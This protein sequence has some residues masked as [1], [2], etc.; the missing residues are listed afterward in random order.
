MNRPSFVRIARSHWLLALL[1]WPLLAAGH[2]SPYSYLVLQLNAAAT[3]G[4]L[5]MHV[6]D[7]AH[8]TGVADPVTL[9]DADTARRY[10]A[11][12][13][14]LAATRMGI[15]FDGQTAEYAWQP[16]VVLPE[17]QSLQL[18]FTLA[19][20]L[21][22]AVLINMHLFPYD[23]KHQS[24]VDI[25][26][27]D[28]L[29]HQAILDA[30][31]T[32]MRYYSGTAQGRW[33]VVKTFV[34]SG[35]HHILIGP[36]HILF[37]IGLLLLGGTLWR[38]AG[39]ATAFTIGHSITL[40]L[41]ALG[42]VQLSPALVEPVIALSIVAVGAD[43]LLVLRQ[44]AT[45]EA[46]QAGQGSRARDLRTVLAGV[47]GLIHGFGFAAVLIEFGLPGDALGWSLASFNIGV[48][49]GQLMI[50][51]PTAAALWWLGRRRPLLA[52]RVTWFAS[53]AVILAGAY[54]FVERVWF[55]QRY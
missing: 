7:A 8:E 30:T 11:Q 48:E 15:A 6:F 25:Y 46:L 34:Q 49:V 33:A 17:R 54:W 3:Q 43:N 29:R 32:S 5:V 37:L 50:V 53:L 22:S 2:D 12:L 44:R 39:I 45:L 31:K 19:Q 40:S 16:L 27:G 20:P 41:A 24:F 36:D 55:T 21:P 52:A 9:L 23:P 51:L 4:S 47:F 10:E 1:L 26:E 38:L 35:V 18:R 14:Q 13:R 42:L 28:Q